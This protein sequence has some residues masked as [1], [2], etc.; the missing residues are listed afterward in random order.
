MQEAISCFQSFDR[1]RNECSRTEEKV[2]HV[3]EFLDLVG[4]SSTSIAVG[5]IHNSSR[6]FCRTCH[7][8]G[9]GYL[10]KSEYRVCGRSHLIFHQEPRPEGSSGYC[11]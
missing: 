7:G 2:L 8:I 3:A 10:I 4:V 6:D 1:Q 5:L 11:E 9:A